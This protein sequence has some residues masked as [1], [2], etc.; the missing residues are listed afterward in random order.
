[1]SLFFGILVLFFPFVVPYR[2]W[3]QRVRQTIAALQRVSSHAARPCDNSE[4]VGQGCEGKR[5]RRE[6]EK[7]RVREREISLF[8]AVEA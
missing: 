3:Y 6:R 2:A 8:G 4:G 5:E 1:M 7:E